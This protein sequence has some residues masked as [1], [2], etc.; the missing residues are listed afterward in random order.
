MSGLDDLREA[1]TYERAPAPAT[2]VD[3]GITAH[4]TP[5]VSLWTQT[6]TIGRRSVSWV[7]CERC[8]W[9]RMAEG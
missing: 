9:R 3:C 2:C 4:A 8:L 7:V 5:G 1:T 6:T